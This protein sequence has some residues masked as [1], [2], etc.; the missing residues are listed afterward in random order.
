[1][2][3]GANVILVDTEGPLRRRQQFLAWTK[4]GWSALINYYGWQP[5]QVVYTQNVFVAQQYNFLATST[6][7]SK[8]NVE[9]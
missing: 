9:V 1:M 4:A 8:M 5:G 2:F 3:A 7:S 6:R